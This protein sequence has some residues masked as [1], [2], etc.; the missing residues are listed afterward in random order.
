VTW[1]DDRGFGFIRPQQGGKELFFHVSDLDGSAVRPQEHMGVSYS[2]SID[3]KGRPCAVGVHLNGTA[4]R[5]AGWPIVVA[6]LFFVTLGAL[7][8][9]GR[10]SLW[11]PILYLTVSVVTMLVYRSDKSRAET[12]AWRTPEKVLHLLELAGGW[13]GALVAQ[14]QF[15]HKNRKT[16]YQIAFWFIVAVN[17]ALLAMVGTGNL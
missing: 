9:A 14:W 15:R 5:A 12:G 2:A 3:D 10:F 7:C 8:L 17:L 1:N 13:P 16:S 4:L 6:A 11:V